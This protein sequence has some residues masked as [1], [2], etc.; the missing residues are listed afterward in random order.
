MRAVE[1]IDIVGKEKKCFDLVSGFVD[2]G[3]DVVGRGAG[4]G[5]RILGGLRLGLDR[6]IRMAFIRVKEE[7]FGSILC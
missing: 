7:S 6:G 1:A 2:G 4:F 3:G 5:L